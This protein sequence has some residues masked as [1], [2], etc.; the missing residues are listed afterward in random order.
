MLSVYYEKLKFGW[1]VD[2]MKRFDFPNGLKIKR[3]EPMVLRLGPE[4]APGPGWA[5]SNV[6]IETEEGI[7]GWGEAGV[8]FVA[9]VCAAI[10]SYGQEMVGRSAWEVGRLLWLDSRTREGSPADYTHGSVTQAARSALDIALWDIIG[11]KLNVPVYALLGGKVHER[12]RIYGHPFNANPDFDNP[13]SFKEWTQRLVETG[14]I[15][16]KLDPFRASMRPDSY[17]DV[18]EL[19]TEQ[20]EFATNV[21]QAI[22]EG[23]GSKFTIMVECHAR[24]NVATAIR[25][26]EAMKPF[27]PFW[28]E[29]PVPPGNVSAMREVQRATNI[30][31]ATGE[32]IRSTE[33]YV[34]LLTTHACRILQPDIGHMG[35]ITNLKKVADMADNFYVSIAPHGPFGPVM[36]MASAHVAATIPNFLIQETTVGTLKAFKELV[37]GY[38]YDPQYIDLPEAPG[39]GLEISDEFVRERRI[40]ND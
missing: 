20:L 5:T 22:R 31:I 2:F 38:E 12:V 27:N 21:I 30:P 11:K 13:E 25:I 29:E 32:R 26:A 10:E 35:G 18:R 19:S 8:R 14:I 36:V 15:A 3:I 39:L 1:E 34:P 16:G 28:I 23:G 17:G 7:I 40:T 4:P 24:F 37:V 9:P 6:R 33:E